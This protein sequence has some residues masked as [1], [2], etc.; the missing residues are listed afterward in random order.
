MKT[1]QEIQ[2]QEAADHHADNSPRQSRRDSMTQRARMLSARRSRRFSGSSRRRWAESLLIQERTNALADSNKRAIEKLANAVE[3]QRDSI[4][5]A[6]CS[7]VLADVAMYVGIQ[8][9]AVI[10]R[11]RKAR[12]TSCPTCRAR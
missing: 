12:R 8:E 7:G 4:N 11:E 2:A 10:T 6:Y 9:Q 5:S 3:K 1:Q